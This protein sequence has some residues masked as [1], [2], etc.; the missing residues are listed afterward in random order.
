MRTSRPLELVSKDYKECMQREPAGPGEET[1]SGLALA[2]FW[3][4]GGGGRY[5]DFLEQRTAGTRQG[6]V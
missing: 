4:P 2:P 3:Q 6:C 1:L 5:S